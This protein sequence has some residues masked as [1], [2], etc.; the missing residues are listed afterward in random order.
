MSSR[1]L[2]TGCCT[3]PPGTATPGRGHRG[4]CTCSPRSARSARA[5][6]ADAPPSKPRKLRS[7]LPRVA[8]QPDWLAL[9]PDIEATGDVPGLCDVC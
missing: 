9:M 1:A 2:A 3:K 6:L 8:Q 5:A 7:P 4:F